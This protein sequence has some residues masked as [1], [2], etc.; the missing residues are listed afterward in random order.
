MYFTWT[1]ILKHKKSNSFFFYLLFSKL[2]LKVD[3]LN[4]FKKNIFF[5]NPTKK[6]QKVMNSSLRR[7]ISKTILVHSGNECY[8]QCS[9]FQNEKCLSAESL[10]V[11][12]CNF[13]SMFYSLQRQHFPNVKRIY[14]YGYD[15][16]L[17]RR[18][19]LLQDKNVH[20]IIPSSLR[21]NH[22]SNKDTRVEVLDVD[23]FNDCFLNYRE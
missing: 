15:G 11:V 19:Q 14:Y 6:K 7:N 4:K 20:I 23:E 2:W 17:I 16:E 12:G 21:T 1:I 10:I 18:I 22:F 9:L 3:T 5:L 8:D 13:L